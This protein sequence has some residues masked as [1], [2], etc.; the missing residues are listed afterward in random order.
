MLILLT[1]IQIILGFFLSIVIPILLVGF[2]RKYDGRIS[3]CKFL[4]NILTSAI[5]PI[6]V[7][8]QLTAAKWS[9][10]NILLKND[11]IFASFYDEVI[12]NIENLEKENTKI[13]R[14]HLS[15]GSFAQMALKA[16]LLLY[17]NSLTKTR[18]GL[19]AL[20]EKNSIDVLGIQ[21]SPNLFIGLLLAMDMAS[22]VK[23]HYNAITGSFASNYKFTGKLTVLLGIISSTASRMMSITL[24]FSPALG[25]FNLLHHYQGTGTS[26]SGWK[27]VNCYF[28]Q[29]TCIDF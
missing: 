11:T 29:K 25:L 16:I 9:R 3:F 18:Q 26:R 6:Q 28:R 19:V 1:L 12:T 21:L 4:T 8:F 2:T 10:K 13:K 7:H 17:A 14:L 22:F 15:F 5:Y 20:F 23:A 27:I 24:Y